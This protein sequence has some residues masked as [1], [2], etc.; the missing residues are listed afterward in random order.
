MRIGDPVFALFQLEDK[1]WTN[2]YFPAKIKELPNAANENKL[3]VD[4]VTNG[5]DEYVNIPME[6]HAK[7]RTKT[8]RITVPMV[9]RRICAGNTKQFQTAVQ[10]SNKGRRIVNSVS[11]KRKYS[12]IKAKEPSRKAKKAKYCDEAEDDRLCIVC[13]EH[14]KE[15]A[16]QPCGHLCLCAKCPVLIKEGTK[17]CPICRKTAVSFQRIFY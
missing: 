6:N 7:F 11:R 14:K 2:I 4:Y 9:I 13:C 1:S 8:G 17:S 15:Y 10:N 12:E 5:D 16:V 3:I